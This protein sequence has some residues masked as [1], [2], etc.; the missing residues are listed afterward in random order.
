MIYG[1][2]NTLCVLFTGIV[3]GYVIKAIKDKCTRTKAVKP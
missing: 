3:I 1:N 2:L